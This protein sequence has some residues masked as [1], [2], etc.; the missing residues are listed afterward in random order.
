MKLFAVTGPMAS[1]KNTVCS[2]LEEE[3]FACVDA[4]ILAHKAVE[5]G[6]EKI[7]QQ[8][9][10]IAEEKNI[11]L[12][13]SDG[14]INRRNLGQIVFLSEENLKTQEKIVHPIVTQMMEDFI[15]ENFSQNKNVVLNATVLYKT[16][17]IKKVDV[18][19]YVTAPFLKRLFR[20]IQR[21]N[22]KTSQILSRFR[23]QKKLFAKYKFLNADIYRVNNNVSIDKLRDKILKI[24]K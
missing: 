6:K 8:F 12:L 16:P 4:D 14:T 9:S 11:S 2:I 3:G 1:G 22:M 21:D 18:I 17:L 20:V 24:I 15:N 10:K 19:I 5:I 7:L 13:N 23:S